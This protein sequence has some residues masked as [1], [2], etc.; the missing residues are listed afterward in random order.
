[1]VIGV[2]M[3]LGTN[4]LVRRENADISTTQRH[5][6]GMLLARDLRDVVDAMRPLLGRANTNAPFDPAAR[7]AVTTAILRLDTDAYG[8]GAEYGTDEQLQKL[9]LAW[10]SAVESDGA[11]V[12]LTE[13]TKALSALSLQVANVTRSGAG[14]GDAAESLFDAYVFA[15]PNVGANVA[16]NAPARARDAFRDISDDFGRAYDALAPGNTAKA[17]VQAVSDAL[18]DYANVDASD[19]AGLEKQKSLAGGISAR[20]R[21]L[22][23]L[24]GDNALR[25]FKDRL[26]D[27]QHLLIFIWAICILAMLVPIAIAVLLARSVIANNMKDF[28]NL[29]EERDRERAELETERMRNALASSEARFAAVF[30][31]A[32]L[33]VAVLDTQGKVARKNDALSSMFPHA[34]AHD[35]GA[36][37][38][39]F[40][41]LVNGQLPG[42]GYE[43]DASKPDRRQ[44]LDVSVSLVHDHTGEAPYALSIIKD[45]TERRET[46]ERLL[47]ESR[48]DTLVDLPNR[49]FLMERMEEMGLHRR[50]TERPRGVLFIDVDGF[51]VVN[52]SLG[53]EIGDHVLV[54]AARRLEA[55][56]GPLDF[57]ARFGSDEF[58][59]ILE[60]R[61]SRDDLIAYANRL[62]AKLTDPFD[63]GG[64][65]VYVTVSSGLAIC[66]RPYE[67]VGAIVRDADTAMYF[68]KAK[69]QVGCAVFD[70]TMREAATRRL[71]LAAQLRRALERGQL[72]LTFQPVIQIATAK[73]TSME[74]LLRWEHP[75]LGNVQPVEFIPVAEE[76][77]LI[78]PIGRFVLERACAQLADWRRD[79]SEFDNTHLAVNVS[80]RELLQLDYCDYVEQTIDRFGLHAGDITLEVT[81]SAVLQSDRYAEGTLDRLKRAGVLL[82]IDDFGT[83]YSSLRYLQTFPFDQLKIDGSF[84][85]GDGTGLA[86]EPIITMLLALGRAFKVT[87][88]AEGVETPEQ[89]QTLY[90]LGCEY[91]Q[92]FLLERPQI[93][94]SI[95]EAIRTL[96][97]KP[98]VT[99]AEP[100][101]PE[102]SNPRSRTRKTAHR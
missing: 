72:Y 37:Y 96:E 23:S 56:I 54:A 26:A 18:D 95:P 98:I 69:A 13:M 17:D 35:L 90:E 12:H 65:E 66:D 49:N 16:R 53:H 60:G 2:A 7:A 15:I 21:G 79:H 5:I 61:G 76:I 93:A 20:L 99:I 75:T 14:T 45:I 82:S 80:A 88:V 58:V 44:W 22:E 100:A 39:E 6:D 9:D 33:G 81:E 30:D 86:S 59:L 3:I 57:V 77:G 25:L 68:A 89:L 85:R 48:Y 41:Q 84:V 74:V 50:Q 36:R 34:S 78:V 19:A 55:A 92:G 10:K 94:A 91:A 63:I 51:K 101:T 28:S 8:R 97:A 24:A 31:R 52:D 102:G 62:A 40:D 67:S 4:A 1:M 38:P 83:G 87:V 32:S 46:E 29:R 47:R 11:G 73:V 27:E 64:R 43:I 42:F 71:V 70:S